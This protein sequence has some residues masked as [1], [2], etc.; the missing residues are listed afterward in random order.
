MNSRLPLCF[1][2]LIVLLT[3]CGGVEKRHHL[4][5]VAQLPTLTQSIDSTDSYAL[6]QLRLPEYLNEYS[7]VYATSDN[8]IVIDRN[9][10][11]AQDLSDNMRRVLQARIGQALRNKPLYVYPLNNTIRPD[12]IIDIQ[13]MDMLA[14][15]SE[16]RFNLLAQWQIFTTD[17]RDNHN[18]EL[19]KHYPL[20]D[21]EATTIITTYQQALEDLSQAII[22]SL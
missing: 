12:K 4:L 2:A 13:I 22:L 20:P 21:N 15:Q 14:N 17:E 11:W 6:R 8:E 19:S 9:H 1:L 18:H 16:Q 10:L 5:N 7:L 3:A